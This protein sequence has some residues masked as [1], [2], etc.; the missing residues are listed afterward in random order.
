MRKTEVQYLKLIQKIIEDENTKPLNRATENSF[1][2]ENKEAMKIKDSDE[3]VLM[4]KLFE[5]LLQFY[6]LD[7]TLN[8]F[9]HE[10]NT[11]Q[12]TD[13]ETICEFKSKKNRNKYSG[14]KSTLFVSIVRQI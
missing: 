7:Y 9:V 14:Q 1:G 12:L 6:E 4:C 13:N 5:N 8:V 11:S 2:W 3:G 10:V